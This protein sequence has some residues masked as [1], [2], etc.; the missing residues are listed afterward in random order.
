M[1]KDLN[2][3]S[4]NQIILEDNSRY[5]FIVRPF[6]MRNALG[7]VIAVLQEYI[8]MKSETNSE[9]FFCKLYRTKEGNWYEMNDSNSPQE[10]RLFL[11]LKTAIYKHEN[12]VKNFIFSI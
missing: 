1:T 3:L 2:T 8:F 11:S 7:N 5:F 6:E 10:N 12:S 4:I 9:D